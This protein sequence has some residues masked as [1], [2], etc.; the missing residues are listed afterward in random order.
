MNFSLHLTDDCNMRC[1]YC[2]ATPNKN[3]MSREI[4]TASCNLAF[5]AGKTA[6][7]CFFGGEPLLEWSQIA[8]ALDYCHRKSV[9]TGKP[10][11]CKLTTNGTL[12]R[13]EMLMYAKEFDMTIGL[14]IDGFA[15]DLCRRYANGH[16]TLCDVEK[17]ARLLLQKLPLS[18]A[19]M[20][21]AP[22]AADSCAQSVQYLYQLGFRRINATIAYGAHVHWTDASLL[23]LQESFLD[24]AAF[25][26]ERLTQGEYFYFSPFD[27][28]I[29]DCIH[30]QNASAHCH[31]GHRQMSISANGKIYPCTQ[32]VGKEPYCLGD[33]FH[34]ID[35]K[36]QIALVQRSQVPAVC[37]DCALKHRCTN[38]C[39]CLNRM[40]TGSEN[41]IS[42]LQCTYERMLIAICDQMAEQLYQNCRAQFIRRFATSSHQT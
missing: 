5:S 9:A 7:L 18:Y 6:G 23:R 29:R 39:G 25:Y 1:S 11:R 32:F 34:G 20:T 42:P 35:S 17:S 36:R 31:L 28:K 24:I 19:M 16:G 14:S 30:G 2:I 26:S 12:L 21:I 40:E 3:H 41:Q 22:E 13:E 4:L 27:A 33:V 8:F 38:A 37:Q 10:F 15:Q